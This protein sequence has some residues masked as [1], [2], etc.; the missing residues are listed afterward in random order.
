MK[1][2]IIFALIIGLCLSNTLA[3]ANVFNDIKHYT[4][5][6]KLGRGVVNT[7]TSPVEVARQIQITSNE[8]SLLA[9]WT[10]GL[11]GGL[12]QGLIRFGAGV[13]DVFTFPFNF[14]HPHKAPLI[15]PEYVW[16]KPGPRY[17]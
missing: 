4:W 10:L 6:Q 12:A 5:A 15:D 1:K 17:S 14:P 3:H 11:V 7:I 2:K 16:Q 9:G 13:I 8:Q